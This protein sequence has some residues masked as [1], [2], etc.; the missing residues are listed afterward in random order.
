MKTII[1]GL[2][3]VVLAAFT[4]GCGVTYTE[5]SQAVVAAPGAEYYGD[6]Y[7]APAYYYPS[8]TAY[9]YTR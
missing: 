7:V 1:F 9:V 2:S 4:A 8:T 5:R 3:A 6:R